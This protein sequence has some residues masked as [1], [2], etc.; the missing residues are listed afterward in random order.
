[1][2]SRTDL[3]TLDIIHYSLCKSAGAIGAGAL[4][5]VRMDNFV[6][7]YADS[8]L[9]SFYTLLVWRALE[10]FK[11]LHAVNCHVKMNQCGRHFSLRI[12][13]LLTRLL[14][15]LTCLS[16]HTRL[17]ILLLR[18]HTFLLLTII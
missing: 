8:T 9:S 5:R 17:A 13:T 4:R 1:M 12:L 16:K 14:C 10:S 11:L 7:V 18:C 2:L 6:A 15:S 3:N